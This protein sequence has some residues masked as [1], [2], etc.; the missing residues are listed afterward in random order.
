MEGGKIFKK[1]VMYNLQ[2]D[3]KLFYKDG[4]YSEKTDI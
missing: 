1:F 2:E 3:Y 4:K